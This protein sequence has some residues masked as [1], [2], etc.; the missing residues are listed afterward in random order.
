[1]RWRGSGAGDGGVAGSS[2]VLLGLAIR[3]GVAAAAYARRL[4]EL[5]FLGCTLVTADCL[6][7]LVLLLWL[8]HA[9][10]VVEG[11]SSDD[12][13]DDVGPKDTAIKLVMFSR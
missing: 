5:L 3:V 7:V 12:V 1:M 2:S 10:E 6:L 13:E 4:V 8:G 11:E 9:D